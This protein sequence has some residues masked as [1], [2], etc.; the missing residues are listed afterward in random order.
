LSRTISVDCPEAD[1]QSLDKQASS[2]HY[3]L[4]V[5]MEN[6]LVRSPRTHPDPARK[7]L[8]RSLEGCASKE[9]RR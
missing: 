4:N 6:A 1:Q 2:S 5:A 3:V 7:L 9:D 8:D